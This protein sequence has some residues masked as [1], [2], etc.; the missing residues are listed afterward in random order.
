MAFQAFHEIFRE[1]SEKETRSINVFD[2]P[3]LPDDSYGLIE[4]YCNDPGCECRRV[5]FNIISMKQEKV[6][7][8]I[9]F[10]WESEEFYSKWMGSTDKQTIK[11]LKGPILNL[12]SP[13]SKYAPKLLELITNVVLQDKHYIERLVRHYNLFR[14]EIDN[15]LQSSEGN[16]KNNLI[17]FT[18]KVGRNSPCPCG[19]GK[20][21]KKCCL[22]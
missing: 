12:M 22:E 19:S 13:Q 7:A 5:F 17:S 20:K 16:K 3:G 6:L 21:Y 18:P 1:I 8:V 11:D 10:G 9:S 14:Q 4:L 2:S 15:P